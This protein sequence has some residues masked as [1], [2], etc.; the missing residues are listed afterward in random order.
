MPIY[1]WDQSF[2]LTPNRNDVALCL[3]VGPCVLSLFIVGRFHHR[4][5]T[6]VDLA[7]FSEKASLMRSKALLE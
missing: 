3:E 1:L 5:V 4:Q 7:L 6:A 2:F